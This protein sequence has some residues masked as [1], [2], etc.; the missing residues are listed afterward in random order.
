MVE[1]LDLFFI[2][3]ENEFLEGGVLELV[4]EDV[5]GVDVVIEDLELEDN[6]GYGR[7]SLLIEKLYIIIKVGVGIDLVEFC[8]FIGG[9][10]DV[11]FVI[12]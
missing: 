11:F 3:Y 10:R 4:G 8:L 7:R 5:N 12:V 1:V 6:E 9:V 2:L